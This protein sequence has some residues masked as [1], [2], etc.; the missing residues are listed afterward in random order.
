MIV[1][2]SKGEQKTYCNYYGNQTLITEEI[3]KCNK[4]EDTN[5]PTEREMMDIAWTISTDKNRK[6]GFDPPKKKE[7][8]PFGFD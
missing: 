4:H 5:H 2:N 7:R 6:M 1:E 8:D 3:A